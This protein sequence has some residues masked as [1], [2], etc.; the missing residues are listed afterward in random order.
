MVGSVGSH[1]ILRS[2][3]FCDLATILNFL[4]RWNRKIMRFYDPD[5]DFDNHASEGKKGTRIVSS[6]AL[7]N[8]GNIIVYKHF[9]ISRNIV[10]YNYY[11]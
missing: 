10:T 3:H 7:D 6:I 1:M 4:M 11:G 9:K 2:Y 8:S 5:H